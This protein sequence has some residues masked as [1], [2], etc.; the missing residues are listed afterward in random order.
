MGDPLKKRIANKGF[1]A[2]DCFRRACRAINK[3]CESVMRGDCIFV[4]SNHNCSKLGLDV[5][6][7]ITYAIADIANNLFWRHG[8][9]GLEHSLG[10]LRWVP[11][12]KNKNPG[13]AGILDHER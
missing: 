9:L 12:R 10:G 3:I 6:A 5:V 2:K 7:K 8:A 4:T 13:V 1:N 11:K